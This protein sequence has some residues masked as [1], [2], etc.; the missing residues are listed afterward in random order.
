MSQPESAAPLRPCPIC[1]KP[2]T[3]AH[4]PF[5]S[6]RCRKVDLGRWFQGAYAIPAKPEE[7]ADLDSPKGTENDDG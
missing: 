3:P 5:C 7:D 1:R 2:A 4:R 6:D